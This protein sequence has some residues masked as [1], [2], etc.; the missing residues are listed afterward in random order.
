MVEDGVSGIITPTAHSKA[1]AYSMIKLIEDD[2]LR[3]RLAERGNEKIQ[4]FTWENSYELIK[5]LL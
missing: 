5:S 2:E 3:I 1:L 4:S